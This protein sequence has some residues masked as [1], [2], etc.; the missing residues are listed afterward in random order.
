MLNAR[1]TPPNTHTLVMT[2]VLTPD[3]H[4]AMLRRANTAS[5]TRGCELLGRGALRTVYLRE[6]LERG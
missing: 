1:R 6:L 4:A 5:T 3:T 2:A